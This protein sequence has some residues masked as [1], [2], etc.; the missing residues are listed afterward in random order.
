MIV[1]TSEGENCIQREIYKFL[2]DF[3]HLEMREFRSI[4]NRATDQI[5]YPFAPIQH[6][7]LLLCSCLARCH[8]SAFIHS[9]QFKW[10][11]TRDNSAFQKFVFCID[12]TQGTKRQMLCFVRIFVLYFKS[13]RAS[14]YIVVRLQMH[15]HIF[16]Q[17]VEFDGKFC[18]IGWCGIK[19]WWKNVGLKR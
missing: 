4:I 5:L 15:F 7:T 16:T 10:T 2:G 3:W 11:G 8:A 9:H 1:S 14:F 6:F 17:R 13:Y 12:V 19:W 18:D